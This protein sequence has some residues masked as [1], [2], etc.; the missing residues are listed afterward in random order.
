MTKDNGV[1][2][3]GFLFLFGFFTYIYTEILGF[4]GAISLLIYGVFL[5]HYNV[6]NM[7]EESKSSSSNTFIL[8]A[9]ISEGLLFLIMGI[10]VWQGQW[11]S[12]PSDDDKMTHSYI[13]FAAVMGILLVSRFVNV[14]VLGLLGRWL[15]KGKFNVCNQELHILFLSGMVRG[16]VPF[17]LFSSV[18]FPDRYSKNEGIVL[19]TTI[20]FVIIFTSV[21]LNSIIPYIYKRGLKKLTL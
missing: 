14:Y 12:P 3:T 7:S 21:I 2:E 10:M 15:S 5:N 19:K 11:E 16:A 6:Y 9:N 4:S 17:V 8:L 20:I 13:F 18:N 1:T